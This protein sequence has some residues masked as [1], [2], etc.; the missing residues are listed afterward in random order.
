MN[1]TEFYRQVVASIDDDD[2]HTV[3]GILAGHVGEENLITIGDL[4]RQAFGE[5]TVSSER[6]TREILETLTT[7]HHL[8]VCSNSGRPGRWL[9]KDD[10]E[11]EAAARELEARGQHVLD[12]ARALRL[13]IVPPKEFTRQRQPSLWR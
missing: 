11:R 6:K 13:A 12:R 1:P 4:A 5:F 10:E 3:A 9:A 7:K 2:V 8:P